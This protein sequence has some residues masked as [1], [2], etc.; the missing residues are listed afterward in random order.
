E[1]GESA[2]AE[3][4]SVPRHTVL[5]GQMAKG[6]QTACEY[7]TAHELKLWPI[8]VVEADYSTSTRDVASPEGPPTPSCR[9][10]IRIRLR[11]TGGIPFSDVQLDRLPLWLNG[12]G[13]LPH[14]IYEQLLADGLGIVVRPVTR[15]A[16]W[17]EFSGSEDRRG[18]GFVDDEALLPYDL[19]S[20]QG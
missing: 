2:L 10:V 11:T 7:R 3:G 13:E 19:R 18:L 12:P 15:P 14:H 1:K 9:A 20:F 5:R 17:H 8:E 16:P 6:D 4:I